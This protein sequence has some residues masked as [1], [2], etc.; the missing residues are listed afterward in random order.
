MIVKSLFFTEH[1][2]SPGNFDDRN[3]IET[4]MVLCIPNLNSHA[5]MIFGMR[6]AAQAGAGAHM[7]VNL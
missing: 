1:T 2:V 3:N 7:A 5:S 4:T 6:A